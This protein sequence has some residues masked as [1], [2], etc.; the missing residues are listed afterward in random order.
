MTEI[1][2]KQETH[3][4]EQI[5]KIALQ[6]GLAI[7][8]LKNEASEVASKSNNNSI[9]EKLYSSAEFAPRCAEFCGAAYKN[10]IEAGEKIS[11]KCHAGL[12]YDAVLLA[13]GER[14]K[15]L[16]A[17]I[18][19]TFAASEEYKN[20][21]ERAMSGDW[22]QFPADE[23]FENVH[24]A[25]S[26]REIEQ[27]TKKLEKLVKKERNYFVE[28]A[29]TRQLE[30]RIEAE[31]IA[32]E[33]AQNDEIS[34]MIAE[35]HKET[36]PKAV[37]LE[38]PIEENSE[39]SEES[40]VWR[41]VFGSLLELEYK[42]ASPA[43]LNFLASRHSLLNLVWLENVGDQLRPISA[44]GEFA[45][46]PL[47]IA[48][49]ADDARLQDAIQ[50]ETSLEL[51]E[52]ANVDSNYKPKM[53]NLFPVAIGGEVISALIVADDLRDEE[54]KR[55]IVRFVQNISPELEI[56]RLREKVERQS[57]TEKAIRQ[58]NEIL[59]EIDEDRFWVSAAQ[60]SAELM[61][62]ERGSLLVVNDSEELTVKA[63]VGNRADAI[64]RE[65]P[66]EIG[67]RVAL[68][69]LESGKP[70]IVKNIEKENIAPAPAE[71]KYK[72]D[73]FISYP[74]MIGGRKIG[75][76][77]VTDT[78]DGE[79]YNESDL[80]LL[81]TISPQLA[82]AL[83]RTSLKRQAVELRQISITDPLT[84]LLNRRYLEERLS[85]EI[86]RSQRHGYPLSFMMIDVDEFKSYNDK[87][88]HPEGD[89]A[90]QIVGQCLKSTLRA[91]D[92]AARYG[93]EEF[94][95]LL[96]QTN[97]NEFP[98]RKV[99]ISVGIAAC[100]AESC[101]AKKLMSAADKALYQAKGKGRNNVQI[102][103]EALSASE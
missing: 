67:K 23:L 38:R 18:G 49:S 30:E 83:D 64:K 40:A 19:R 8:V 3:H 62:A 20:A 10:A 44:L 11:V 52:R 53:I 31:D 37:I 82:V 57:R 93:G 26:E 99:T 90:L 22:K 58:I 27:T 28:I 84:G 87:F 47:E 34:K 29:E 81:N 33:V 54:M 12:H 86:N 25:N 21:V 73:S 72:T 100:G 76:L 43:I 13:P 94:S 24:L 36:H 70:L 2:E 42:N 85:E 32:P 6:Q 14:S 71:W 9:C 1:R 35:F 101:D 63:A 55:H 77:N 51:R 74:I 60:I 95:I 69:V 4:N 79:I 65:K 61:R 68:K 16:V 66:Q 92:V 7:V 56:L 39:E 15:P 97:I 88:S 5:E 98:N 91:A 45:G 89:K 59:K 75:V 80:E 41:S 17:I 46:Q 48:I 102:Y 50:K 103:R 96:P 78:I